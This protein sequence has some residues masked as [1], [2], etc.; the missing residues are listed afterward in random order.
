MGAAI[1]PNRFVPARSRR[2]RI[3]SGAPRDGSGEQAFDGDAAVV[4]ERFAGGEF[5]GTPLPRDDFDGT[6]GGVVD[7]DGDFATEAVEVGVGDGECEEGGGGG[8]GGVTAGFEDFQAC[9]DGLSAAGHDGSTF[10]CRLPLF[11]HGGG[12]RG[13]GGASFSRY[14]LLCGQ[15]PA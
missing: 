1:S 8:I 9:F 14:G 6:A 11:A 2:V 5:G 13:G 15:P 10:A 7:E 12:L 3:A 4:G